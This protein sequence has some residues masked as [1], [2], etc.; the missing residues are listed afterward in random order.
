MNLEQTKY[1]RE[2]RRRMI[3]YFDLDELQ[4]LTND[5]GVDWDE[6]S[7]NKKS[8]KSQ[9]L[10]RYL[11]QRGRIKYLVD[12]LKE[13]RPHVDW[14][15]IRDAEQQILDENSINPDLIKLDQTLFIPRD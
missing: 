3:V 13:E 14:P 4:I 5:L 2:I 10:I 15:P 11:A 12:L 7:G 9:S 6:L 8:T 1:M